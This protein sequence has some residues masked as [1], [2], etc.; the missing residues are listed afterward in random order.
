MKE[1]EGYRTMYNHTLVLKV[2]Q[3]LIDPELHYNLYHQ[4]NNLFQFFSV[5]FIRL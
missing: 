2:A 3:I 1:I 5:N 4:L